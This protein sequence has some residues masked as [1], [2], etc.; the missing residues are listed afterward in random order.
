VSP[1]ARSSSFL[2]RMRHRMTQKN[3]TRRKERED[4]THAW[5]L[6][7]F[8]E[9]CAMQPLKREWAEAIYACRDYPIDNWQRPDNRRN[10][11]ARLPYRKDRSNLSPST[12]LTTIAPLLSGRGSIGRPSKRNFC[13][14]SIESPTRS[15]ASPLLSFNDHRIHCL[16]L[17]TS[18]GM[19]LAKVHR[20]IVIERWGNR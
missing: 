14:C 18:D 10:S 1:R 8:L 2:S 9:R 13:N 7:C 20:N 3:E 4:K 6:I 5:H 12:Y 17:G 11:V 19:K 15:L 16:D